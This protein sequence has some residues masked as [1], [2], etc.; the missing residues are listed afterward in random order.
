[1]NNTLIIALVVF[2][3]GMLAFVLLLLCALVVERNSPK[4]REVEI[5]PKAPFIYAEDDNSLGRNGW[6][7]VSIYRNKLYIDGILR[8]SPTPK[9]FWIKC[10]PSQ[11]IHTS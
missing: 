7:Q 9:V 2:G 8:V 3:Y 5:N 6:H 10:N 11:E 4:S 1:M